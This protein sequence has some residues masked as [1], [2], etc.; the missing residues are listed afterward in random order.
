MPPKLRN[1]KKFRDGHRTFVRNTIEEAKKLI[2]EGNPIDVKRLKCLRTTLET[3]YPELQSLDR[4]I[5]DLVDDVKAIDN[6]VSESC[7]LMSSIQEC[8]VELESALEAQE[9]QGK[10]QELASAAQSSSNESAGTSQDH[11][12][13]VHTHAK[14]PK[15]ELKK[16]HGNPIHWYPFWESFDS[17]VHKNPNL[18]S[19]DKFNYLQSLLTGTARSAIAGLALTSANYKKAVGLLKQRF[20]NRQIVISSHIEVLTKLPKVES[21]NEVKKLRSLYDTVESHVRGLESM[22]ISSEMYGCFLTPIVM[23]K[24]PEEFRIAITRNLESE[25]WNL[26][27]ILSEFHKELQLREQCLV[28]NKESRPSNQR[29][30]LPPSTSASLFT[31]NRQSPRVW[32]SFCNQNHQS[33]KCNVVTSTESRKEVLKKK[34]KCFLCLKQGH[35]A[36]NCQAHMKCLKCQGA[37]H[38]AICG[39][40]DHTL[41]GQEQEHVASEST[42]MYVD[43]SRGSVLFADCNR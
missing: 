38:V 42:S 4:E 1:L 25:T 9:R 41:G 43:Q 22:E 20:G 29:G 3:K 33:S 23:Q 28:S 8:I 36:R 40:S 7:D 24:L 5:V 30:E 39:D 19:V 32:C 34:G 37:H 14:L 27:D 6:E 17:A 11:V 16:F 21:I 13:K 2:A 26:K 10:S 35:L 12:S 18:S 31:D 15:L